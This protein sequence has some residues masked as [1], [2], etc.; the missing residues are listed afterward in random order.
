MWSTKEFLIINTKH[1]G[2]KDEKTKKK[3]KKKKK[4]ST[5]G[6]HQMPGFSTFVRLFAPRSAYLDTL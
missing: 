6:W 3:N 5:G 2:L 1:F 4:K